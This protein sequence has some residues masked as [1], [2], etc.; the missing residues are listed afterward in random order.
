MLQFLS[1]E[2]E[3]DFEN[4]VDFVNFN[5]KIDMLDTKLQNV[6]IHMQNQKKLNL[7]K[8]IILKKTSICV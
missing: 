2:I 6:I 1:I 8:K 5:K 3:I 7:L 4:H